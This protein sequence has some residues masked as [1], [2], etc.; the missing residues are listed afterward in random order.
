[1]VNST[2]LMFM[3]EQKE[4]NSYYTATRGKRPKVIF[5]PT[6]KMLHVLKTNTDDSPEPTNTT[7]KHEGK[8]MMLWDRFLKQKH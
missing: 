1:M 2:N 5:G 3:E 7:V 6:W 8:S 4:E